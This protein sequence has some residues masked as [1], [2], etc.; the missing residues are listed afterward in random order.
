MLVLIDYA[1]PRALRGAAGRGR[2]RG[3]SAREC[4]V[5]G[6]DD[7]PVPAA[8]G[9]QRRRYVCAQVHCAPVPCLGCRPEQQIQQGAHPATPVCSSWQHVEH[10]C[11]VHLYAFRVLLFALHAVMAIQTQA[12]VVALLL[13]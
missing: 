8:R 11:F 12:S 1:E 10:L 9:W 5:R 6:V 13:Q 3:A 2:A 7:V 4:G